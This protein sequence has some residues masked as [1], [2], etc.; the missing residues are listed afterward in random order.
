MPRHR[1][2]GVHVANIKLHD[3]VTVA[4]AN[5]AHVDT[6]LYT[7]TTYHVLPHRSLRYSRTPDAGRPNDLI[8]VGKL[9]VAQAEPEQDIL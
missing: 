1:D 3:L 9:G 6:D 2:R 7:G 5:I 4:F 8:G